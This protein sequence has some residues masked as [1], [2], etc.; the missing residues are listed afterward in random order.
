MTVADE[1]ARRCGENSDIHQHLPRLHA[2][3]SGAK[4]VI[5]LGVRSANSTAAFLAAVHRDGGHVWSVDI[6]PPHV[7]LDWWELGCW[8]FI[9][10]DDLSPDVR[11]QLPAQADVVF[12]D[13]SHTYAQTIA[14]LEVYSQM[15]RPGGVML[16]HDT[17]LERPE[18]ATDLDPPFPVRT[19]IEDF[20][21]DNGLAAEFVT[22]CYGLGV[23]RL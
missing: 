2:E 11:S 16:L 14:E 18:A 19:A 8:T 22:G 12:V 4:Q 10:G 20:C 1:F 3:A 23:I 7:P 21:S 9:H 6:A 15:V 5:E 13:T 17:E